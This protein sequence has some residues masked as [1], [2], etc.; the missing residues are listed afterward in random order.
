MLIVDTP[1]GGKGFLKVPR[2]YYTRTK[3]YILSKGFYPN[4][5]TQDT[6][7]KRGQ[8][9]MAGLGEVSKSVTRVGLSL[10]QR[11]IC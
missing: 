6:S 7:T 3:L 2:E 4:D 1:G 8:S 11:L 5:S 9:T 10:K